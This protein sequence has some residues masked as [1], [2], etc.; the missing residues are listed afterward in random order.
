MTTSDATVAPRAMGAIDSVLTIG[1]I[2]GYFF[3]SDLAGESGIADL[4]C[5]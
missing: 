4:C 2:T 1:A 5:S 3:S